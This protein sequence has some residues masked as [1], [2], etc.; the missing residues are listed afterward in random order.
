MVLKMKLINII[1]KLEDLDE[2]IER[3]LIDSDIE[4]ENPFNVFNNT[5][6]FVTYHGN[7]P[8][9]EVM[10]KF[11]DVFEYAQIPYNDIKP[12]KGEMSAD[13][14]KN[15]VDV[16]DKQIHVLREKSEKLKTELERLNSLRETLKPIENSDVELDKLSELKLIKCR[17]GRLPIDSYRKLED[18]LSELPVYFSALSEDKNYVWGF[19]FTSASECI[20]VDKVMATL[21]FERIWIDNENE[22]GTPAE[23]IGKIN[24]KRLVIENELNELS[25]QTT[26]AI[27]AQKDEILQ[28]FE[29][30]KYYCDLF[31]IKRKAVY[32]SNSFYFTCWAAEREAE[33]ISKLAQDDDRIT[34]ILDEPSNFESVTTPTKIKNFALFKPFEEFIKMYGV[35]S[36]N[37]I[38]PTP[39]LAIVY[40]LLFGMM[41]GDVGHGAVL[42]V[43]GIVMVLMKKGGFLAKIFIP[44]GI[45]SVVFGFLYGTFFGFEGENGVIKPLW[46]T[47]M[48]NSNNMNRILITTVVIGVFII[49]ICMLINVING[50]KQRNWQK[51]FFSQN[52]VAG[53][54]FYGL[55]LYLGVSIFLG[56]KAPFAAASIGIVISLILIFCQEPLGKLCARKKDWMPKEKGGFFVQ[57]FFEL[58]EILL[59]F[60]TNSISFVRVGA[61][62]L[63]HAGM[64]SV[65]LMFMEQLNGAGSVTVAILGNILVIGLEGLIVGIQVL[66][67]GFY[68]MF[69]RFYDGDGREFKSIRG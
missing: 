50:I 66:R 51:T 39:I 36:Y 7:N 12:H 14:L 60:V 47:P 16:F 61:F 26:M 38:D 42:A 9:T 65:V 5:K 46:F 18:Y 17:F 21:Y 53:I 45:S 32:T 24:E 15:M 19:Y 67:L 3:Y 55:A 40:T 63:N 43:L 13:E 68:E 35:P 22:D 28:A 31:E 57:S 2:I 8:Y 48:E 69:S 49:L 34:I 56:S 58:F 52:G 30:V 27:V 11:V 29:V 20:R 62:A 6:G 41:F 1:G 37:E 33:R 59:S 10:K 54:L 25:A 23:I 64:M 4:F 44:L